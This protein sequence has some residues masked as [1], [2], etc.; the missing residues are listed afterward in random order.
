MIGTL[1]IDD[2]DVVREGIRAILLENGNFE[3]KD[4]AGS[5]EE[6]MQ[7]IYANTY[8]LIILD[9]SL[10]GMSGLEFIKDI[11][12]QQQK[13]RVLVVSMHSEEEFAMRALKSGAH[14]Y[15]HKRQ[16]SEDLVKAINTIMQDKYYVADHLT[17]QLINTLKGDSDVEPHNLLSDREYEIMLMLAQGNEVKEIANKLHLSEKTVG[18]HRRNILSKMGL[19]NVVE[20]AVYSVKK[21]LI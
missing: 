1:I 12:N 6:A 11:K 17:N 14:G 2:H 4:T 15:V 10:P 16:V 5:A 8:E 3:I 19:K 21:S 18:A 20:L 13:A 9:L 7:L